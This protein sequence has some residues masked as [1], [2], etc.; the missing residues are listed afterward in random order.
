VLIW[1]DRCSVQTCAH[2]IAET[3][4]PM[5]KSPKDA[6]IRFGR[7]AQDE[8]DVRCGTDAKSRRH[9]T[10][11]VGKVESNAEEESCLVR[12]ACFRAKRKESGD[13]LPLSFITLKTS[14]ILAG[15]SV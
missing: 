2:A 5:R 1:N 12:P 14:G 8:D 11:A 13:L 7:A 10:G 6:S 3:A 4:V 15:V 9:T